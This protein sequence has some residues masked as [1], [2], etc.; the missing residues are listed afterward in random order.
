MH[1]GLPSLIA[2][3]PD[4]AAIRSFLSEYSPSR[5]FSIQVR[6]QLAVASFSHVLSNSVNDDIDSS[7][8][9]LLDLEL[10]GLKEECSDT[11]TDMAEMGFLAAKLY[12]YALVITRV[13]PGAASRNILLKLSLGVSLRIAHLASARLH[14]SSP[15]DTHGLT[16]GQRQRTHPKN[17][18]RTIAFAMVFLLRYFSLNSAAH[19]DEQQL[20]ANHVKAAHQ[21]FQTCAVGPRD[22]F[23]RAAAFFETL[24]RQ[25]PVNADA[26]RTRLAADQRMGVSILFDAL[27]TASEARGRPAEIV[28]EWE[29]RVSVRTQEQTLMQTHETASAT[30]GRMYA[31]KQDP[32]YET[33]MPREMPIG[34]GI[35]GESVSSIGV[36]SINVSS[37]GAGNVSGV[38]EPWLAD[39]TAHGENSWNEPVWDMFGYEVGYP[40]DG[41]HL[42]QGPYP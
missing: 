3:D 17:Y 34:V 13:P 2:S 9:R 4:T 10:D 33:M 42:Q 37:V 38:Q 28:E 22:E 12:V 18:F 27:S 41:V 11:W 8:V 19:A 7:L 16:A 29:A 5:D 36:S 32:S 24:G 31:T 14:N 23:A 26:L 20:A 39:A 1:L 6:I 21:V 15:A 30:V 25:D 35:S 40:P